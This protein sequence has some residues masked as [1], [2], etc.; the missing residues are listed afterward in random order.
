MLGVVYGD[1][2]LCLE[3]FWLYFCDLFGC[4]VGGMLRFVGGG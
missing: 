1:Y 2:Y 3:E 4:V